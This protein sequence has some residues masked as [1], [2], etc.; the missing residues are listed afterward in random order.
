[1]RV[2]FATLP[3]KAHLNAV[4]PL[5]WALRSAGHE[6]VLTG[7]WGPE[8][9]STR[10]IM[11]A[12]LNAVPLGGAGDVSPV[13]P[14]THNRP[15]FLAM[16]PDDEDEDRWNH[17]RDA[18]GYMYTQV[19]A[20]GSELGR[21]SDLLRH[22]VGFTGSWRPDLVLWDALVFP[23][24]V[25]ARLCGAAHARVLWGMDTIGMLRARILT[26]MRD[27]FPGSA[28][29]VGDP[30]VDWL[31][32]LLDPYGL[33]FSEETLLGHWSVDLSRPHPYRSRQK[34]VPVRR[35]PYGGP[36]EPAPWLC[37][38]PPRPRVVLTLGMTRE[39]IHGGQ[40]SFPLRDFLDAARELDVD[41]LT[42]M[43]S[44]QLSA[45]G[46]L[47]DNVRAIGYVPFDLLL[48]TCSAIVHAGGRGT[49][50]SAAAFH[51]PQVIVP[52]SLW[53]EMV[54]ARQVT[55]YGAGLALDPEGL[56]GVSV[57]KALVRVL[58]EPTFR[59]GAHRLYT[60]TMSDPA[61]TDCV[62]RLEQLT[63]LHR[64]A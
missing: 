42:T 12:G 2:V 34:T 41:L 55:A 1:M 15:D 43:T 38:Q 18:V 28:G 23:A 35:I 60:D 64:G 26:E 32:P 59:K 37:E 56:D 46:R 57:Y 29:V 49:F 22:L 10:H 63:A 33:E 62:S 8:R 50:S 19:Y 4:I 48:P 30:C 17:F 14:G 47:P 25:A 16:D 44:G 24:P 61:P 54:T 45:Y 9:D 27:R 36:A 52:Q 58:E 5:A 3:V 20:P 53:D 7:D 21:Q 11:A 31:M 51:V 39:Q 6:V 40:L 13:R